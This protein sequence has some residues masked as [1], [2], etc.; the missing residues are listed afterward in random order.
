MITINLVLHIVT[1][2][3]SSLKPL[4]YVKTFII[5]VT[6]TLL[7]HW[8][9]YDKKLVIKNFTLFTTCISKI[10]NTLIDNAEDLDILMPMFNLIEYI[11]NYS[12]ASGILW[13]CYRDEPN[14]LITD[15]KSLRQDL[16][17]KNQMIM[18]KRNLKLLYY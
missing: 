1:T 18:T 4:C 6:L 17:G 7:L 2:K 15:S 10:K 8:S 3:K 13:N 9:K 12:K 5:V 16:Q 11:K 14:N